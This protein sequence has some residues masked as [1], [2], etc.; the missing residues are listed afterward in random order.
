M[1][2][3]SNCSRIIFSLRPWT[4]L[5]V[6]LSSQ[7]AYQLVGR[8][9]VS[10]DWKGPL[11]DEWRSFKWARLGRKFSHFGRFLH[12]QSF[13]LLFPFHSSKAKEKRFP[14]VHYVFF[15]NS[16]L[17]QCFIWWTNTHSF[18]HTQLRYWKINL[19]IQENTLLY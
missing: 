9:L 17:I 7:W 13:V 6:R 19:E 3:S 16:N 14:L 5:E 10:F 2:D 15:R 1:A 4:F 12:S 11:N 18:T 8:N